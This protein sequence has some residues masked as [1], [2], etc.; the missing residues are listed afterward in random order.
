MCA[1]CRGADR[2]KVR[3]IKISILR[4][5]SSL[6]Y[7]YKFPGPLSEVIICCRQ[8]SSVF[9]FP[10]PP[11]PP[12]AQRTQRWRFSIHRDTLGLRGGGGTVET[13][14]PRLIHV[15]Q[16]TN[17]SLS[18]LYIPCNY[19]VCTCTSHKYMYVKIMFPCSSFTYLLIFLHIYRLSQ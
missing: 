5:H 16:Y 9:P 7:V 4:L 3:I 17:V 6:L 14:G 1:S 15:F 13:Q 2:E 12:P 10:P 8:A 18:S 11:R 19:F